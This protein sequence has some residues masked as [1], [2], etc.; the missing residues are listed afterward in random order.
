MQVGCFYR[1]SDMGRAQNDIFL[2][3]IWLKGH[4]LTD[5]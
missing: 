5:Y 4:V 3:Y 1:Q 2:P